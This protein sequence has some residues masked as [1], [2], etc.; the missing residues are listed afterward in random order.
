MDPQAPSPEVVR[1]PTTNRCHATRTIQGGGKIIY[2]DFISNERGDALRITEVAS[3]K[4]NSVMLPLNMLQATGVG[5]QS[6]ITE[7]TQNKAAGR[8][9]PTHSTDRDE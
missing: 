9:I 8:E 7:G 6:V 2:L 5:I 4:R 3:R 1:V